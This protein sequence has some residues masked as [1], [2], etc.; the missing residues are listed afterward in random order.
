MEGTNFRERLGTRIIAYIALFVACW[1][2]R[3]KIKNKTI[4]RMSDDEELGAGEVG[5]AVARMGRQQN[6]KA[7]TKNK[8]YTD[9]QWNVIDKYVATTIFEKMKLAKKGCLK[10]G[11]VI[12]MVLS[13]LSLSE[14]DLSEDKKKAL[15]TGIMHRLSECRNAARRK[16]LDGV[17]K[18]GEVKKEMERSVRNVLL[19]IVCYFLF[20]RRRE[21][22][23][24]S[25]YGRCHNSRRRWCIVRRSR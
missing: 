25:G 7:V 23:T 5:A 21:N 15:V 13:Q 24:Y 4:S 16:T 18:N 11:R 2:K 19:I 12:R 6:R 9:E 3:R 22:R 10:G 17:G 1:L 8:L 20:F 14:N